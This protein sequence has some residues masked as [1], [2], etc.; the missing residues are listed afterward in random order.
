MNVEMVPCSGDSTLLCGLE[1][2]NFE[3]EGLN[4]TNFRVHGIWN[5]YNIIIKSFLGY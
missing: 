4:G 2:G 5:K 3:D 1:L